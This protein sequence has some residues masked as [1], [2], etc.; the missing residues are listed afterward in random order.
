MIFVQDGSTESV[1]IW[2]S[3]FSIE[4]FHLMSKTY[5]ISR[6]FVF[7]FSKYIFVSFQVI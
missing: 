6:L 1:E 4:I 2:V 5:R 7:F 3:S